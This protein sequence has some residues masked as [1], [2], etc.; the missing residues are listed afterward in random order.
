MMF[1]WGNAGLGVAISAGV[2]L[3]GLLVW[4]AC[5]GEEGA[6]FLLAAIGVLTVAG[7]IGGLS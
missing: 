6:Q 7:L 5:Q 1:D 2:F 3:L 4:R